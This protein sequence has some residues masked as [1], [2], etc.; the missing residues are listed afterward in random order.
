[1]KWPWAALLAYASLLPMEAGAFE[2]T[3]SGDAEQENRFVTIHWTVR[4]I[5]IA[6]RSPGSRTVDPTTTQALI[7]ASFLAWES[8]RCSDLAF[9]Y[10]GVVDGTTEPREVSQVIFQQSGW[11]DEGRD[12][13][14]VALT[15]MTYGK[16]D[17]DIR[18]GVIEVNEEL[19]QFA[20]A[21]Q[22]CADGASYDL[23]AVVT[24]E[25]GHFIGLAHT[26]VVPEGDVRAPTMTAVVVPCDDQFRSLETDDIEG[27][28]F[29]YPAG[30]EARLCATLP[31]QDTPYVQGVAFGCA[32][33]RQ[34]ADPAALGLVLLIAMW[35]LR[36]ACSPPRSGG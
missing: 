16:L 17:G 11:V 21:R 35:C 10:R 27:L 3:L 32:A 6:I 18:F 22:G 14:A 25:A 5:P 23:G 9:E 24:H 30:R 12:P 2:C 34:D 26:R 1:M 36:R 13:S 29:I 19:F 8:S 28:C 20:D 31:R 7:E 4:T 15:T 33:S